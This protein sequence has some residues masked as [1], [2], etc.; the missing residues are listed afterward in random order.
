MKVSVLERG[1][2]YLEGLNVPEAR[3]S[4]EFLLAHVLKTSRSAV[5]VDRDCPESS[6]QKRRFFSLIKKRGH[7]LPLAHVIGTQ[8]FFDF[9]IFCGPG[10]LIPRPE[11]EE[12]VFETCKR[13]KGREKERLSFLEIGAG[14][15][16]ISLVLARH[17][18]NGQVFAIEKSARARRLAEKNR[19]MHPDISKRV[20]L[21]SGDLFKKWNF[22][23]AFFDLIISNPPY[24]PTHEIPDLDAEVLKEPRLAL[25]G[26]ADGLRHL[27]AVISRAPLY[28]KSGGILALEIGSGQGTRVRRLIEESGLKSARILRDISGLDRFA[29]AE[30]GWV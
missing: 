12:L 14:T 23:E 15:G 1:C 29:F 9:K 4:A 7:R 26:G 27:S 25:D 18:P 16:A 21:V 6:A 20:S 28:L 10:A 24:I 13:F 8:P 19:A 30:K 5:Q 11:T 17:F 3:A 2:S 22:P